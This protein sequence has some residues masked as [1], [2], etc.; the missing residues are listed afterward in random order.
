MAIRNQDFPYCRSK[1]NLIVQK[2]KLTNYRGVYVFLP[3]AKTRSSFKCDYL[4]KYLSVTNALVSGEKLMTRVYLTTDVREPFTEWRT[5]PYI[6]QLPFQNK[7]ISEYR[8]YS[9]RGKARAR[10]LAS[11]C[12]MALGALVVE[13]DT[14]ESLIITR[15]FWTVTLTHKFLLP[16]LPLSFSRQGSHLPVVLRVT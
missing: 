6:Y 1:T 5:Y 2:V 15:F 4:F 10:A 3:E 7:F 13:G 11:R 12:A 8:D 14:C 9:T 16:L